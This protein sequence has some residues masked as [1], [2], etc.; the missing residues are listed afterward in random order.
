MWLI[1]LFTLGTSCL[2]ALFVNFFASD[3]EEDLKRHKEEKAKLALDE[4]WEK[5]GER[6][7]EMGK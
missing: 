1:A 7:S 6:Q 2:L 4:A 5:N 3:P